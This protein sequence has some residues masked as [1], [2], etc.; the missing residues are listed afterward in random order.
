M[1]G[2]RILQAP[3]GPW[4]TRRLRLRSFVTRERIQLR[5][6][7]TRHT[8]GAGLVADLLTTS[9]SSLNPWDAFFKLFGVTVNQERLALSSQSVPAAES[10]QSVHVAN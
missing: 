4:R 3:D 1:T 9:I 8:P 6:W 2:L 5:C 10:S 7:T